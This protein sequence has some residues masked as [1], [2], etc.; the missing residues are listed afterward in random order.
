VRLW[1]LGGPTE[2]KQF[3]ASADELYPAIAFSPDGRFFARGEP[4]RVWELGSGDCVVEGGRSGTVAFSPD[5]KEVAVVD[6]AV[7]RWSLPK[8]ASLDRWGDA[9]KQNQ[10]LCL[11]TGPLAYSPDGKTIAV[12]CGGLGYQPNGVL[13]RGR[14]TGYPRIVIEMNFGVTGVPSAIA[15]SP[16]G[17]LL[18][19]IDGPAIGVTDVR[20]EEKIEER[21]AVL[22]PGRKHFS[23]LAF[24]PDGRRLVAVNTDAAVRVYDTAT[25]REVTG[26]EW[27]VGRLTAVAVAPDGLRAACGS[28]RGRVVVWDLDG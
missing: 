8:G 26:Y 1:N 16:D 4:L 12:V 13:L 22:K 2:V 28:D 21:V 19:A 3:P 24:T 18:A 15:F 5:G 27:Q 23:A 11:P 20:I 6:T 25:W 14:N 7:R 17:A 10:G 9:A